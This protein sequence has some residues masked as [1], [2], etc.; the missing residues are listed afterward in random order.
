MS[1][2]QR[3]PGAVHYMADALEPTGRH[4]TTGGDARP[5]SSA[6]SH[7]PKKGTRSRARVVSAGKLSTLFQHFS[8]QYGSDI[9]W[10]RRER[11][12]MKISHMRHT[13]GQDAVKLWLTSEK[14]HDVRAEEVV[15]DPTGKCSDQCVNLFG[16]IELQPVDGEVAPML[17]LLD[18]LCDNDEEVR[19]WLLNWLAL[20]LQ[21][22]GS[23][24]RTAVIVHG[25]EGSGKN[26][27]FEAVRDIYGEYAL[28]VG[29][30]QLE[31]KFNDW[32][33]CKLFII[34]D[35]V[36]T[37]QELRHHKG[38]LKAMISGREVQI[39]TKMM[40][41]RKEANH[42]NLVFLSNELQPLE[43]D[44]TDRR[45]CVMWT[46]P[47]RDKA[48]YGRVGQ[49]L[50][51]GGLAAF[52]AFLLARDLTGFDEFTPP[53][54]SGAKRELIDMGRKSS[55]RFWL[56]WKAGE[57]SGLPF[58]CCSADQA[59]RAYVRWCR[60]EGERYPM[61][62][63]V[64]ARTVFRIAGDQLHRL[65]AGIKANRTVAMWLVTSKP[66]GVVLGTWAAECIEAF[67]EDLRRWSDG[68]A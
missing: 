8:Y 24:M 28:V 44:A 52:Y 30:D 9:A 50:A 49:C 20:P 37:R 57:I 42:V 41:V 22:L 66:E 45:Y 38:R 60:M 17:E 27:F 13:F 56:Q 67:E 48:F 16:G 3:S 34:G 29:Q 21:R 5:A 61:V 53:P 59:Y 31:D 65:T 54:L 62:K 26:L 51:S 19:D 11:L 55:E 10:D 14:R 58:R 25:D 15:F 36:V 4:K 12:A 47:R 64:F 7:P 39:N 18:H 1:E 6:P 33:S 46:P 35:E 40:P 23:K 32:L 2:A 68:P 43:L 63:H